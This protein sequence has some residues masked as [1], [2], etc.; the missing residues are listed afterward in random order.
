M[1]NSWKLHHKLPAHLSLLGTVIL[2]PHG[3]EAA[4]GGGGGGGS[5]ATKLRV[6]LLVDKKSQK[7]LFAEGV[8]DF[9]DFLFSFLVLPLGSITELLTK[10]AMVGAVGQLYKSM[11]EMDV[12]Y[13]HPGQD[14][15]T[16]LQPNIALPVGEP[17]LLQIANDPAELQETKYYTC[18]QVINS[19]YSRPCTYITEV[20]NTACPTCS[21]R[22]SLELAYVGTKKEVAAASS[23]GGRGG[24]VAGVVTYMVM[25]DLVVTPMSTISG[26][27]LLN[28]FN[29]RE[30]GALE[31][32][33]VEVGRNEGM[34]LLEAALQSK[35]VL[36]DV[37]LGKP[38][39]RS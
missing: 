4:A 24:I 23:R 37:F 7:V 19:C 38:V 16:L 17:L 36:T 28:K 25:D 32:M 26:I 29:I 27:T 33:F 2:G 31:E 8:K 34:A 1:L 14:K 12:T 5:M 18:S 30:V 11:E 3:T 20:M 10:E 6:K 21:S 9:I 39:R 35:T 13:I 22:M 15:A